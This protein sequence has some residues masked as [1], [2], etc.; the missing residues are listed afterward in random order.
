MNAQKD[1]IDSELDASRRDTMRILVAGGILAS[2]AGGLLAHAASSSAPP[3]PKQG[4]RIKA[5]SESGSATDTLDP[6]TATGYTDYSR[7]YMF[8]NGLTRLD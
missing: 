4:G 7:A 8:Y 6:A 2:P 3:V 5:A 1:C